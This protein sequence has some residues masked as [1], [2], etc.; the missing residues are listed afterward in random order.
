M[1]KWLVL[2]IIV[3][4]GGTSC[5]RPRADSITT[6][7]TPKQRS[8]QVLHFEEE[9]YS[10]RDQVQPL[11]TAIGAAG[12]TYAG[13]SR[14]DVKTSI[15]HGAQQKTFTTLNQLLTW[16]P[17]DDVIWDRNPPVS[18]ARDSPRIAEENWLVTVDAYLWAA[19]REPDNDY[20]LILGRA[21]WQF[22]KFMTIEISGLPKSG[23]PDRPALK[24]VRDDF[25]AYFADSLPGSSGYAIY[26]DPIPVQVTGCLF[27]DAS[28]HA[29]QVGPRALGTRPKTTWE[30]HPV[31]EIVFEPE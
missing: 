6:F 24:T 5:Q 3:T 31:T 2:G 17:D 21:P 18:T 1:R 30:I 20:H 9:A 10:D 7:Q 23:H 14:G 8:V 28:H 15:C 13:T 22:K 11:D 29:G 26:D 25:K 4:L 27:F 16:L 19:K 12:D